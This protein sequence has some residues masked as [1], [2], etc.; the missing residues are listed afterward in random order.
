[1]KQRRWEHI[2]LVFKDELLDGLQQG[3][4]HMRDDMPR[5]QSCAA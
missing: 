5:F 4:A 1:M 2:C 3:L